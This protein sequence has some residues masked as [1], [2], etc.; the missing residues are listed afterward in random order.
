MVGGGNKR[1][2]RE[3]LRLVLEG[4]GVEEEEE[5]EEEE[6]GLVCVICLSEVEEGEVVRVLRC[7]HR[8]HS[9]EGCVDRWLK[10]HNS[11]PVCKRQAVC[12]S[13]H[14]GRTEV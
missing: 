4:E 9:G 10:L 3:E 12:S 11:C 6:D 2:Q 5:E 7:G 1:R 13:P 8:F 14:C